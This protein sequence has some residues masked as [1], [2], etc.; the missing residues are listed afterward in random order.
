MEIPADERLLHD[1]VIRQVEAKYSG[2]H[3][4]IRSNPGE[5]ENFEFEGF[6]PDV[7]L[8]SYGQ[9][10]QIVEV[11]TESAINEERAAYWEKLSELSAQL[12]LLVPAELKTRAAD[13]CW[14]A[15]LAGRV[16]IGTYE[17]SIR[18]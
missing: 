12:V 15:G 1:W 11:E 16:N 10:V 9:V 17:V 5:E 6:F 4:E 7:I 18:M 13:L 2:L 14:K 8:G 3:K